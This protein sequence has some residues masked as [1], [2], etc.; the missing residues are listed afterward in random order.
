MSVDI[1][2]CARLKPGNQRVVEIEPIA[3]GRHATGRGDRVDVI[4]RGHGVEVQAT[5]T[6][7]ENKITLLGTQRDGDERQTNKENLFNDHIDK[8]FLPQSRSKGM[9]AD[10]KPLTHY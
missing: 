1:Q 3:R 9:R 7:G 2:W 4:G 6:I 10:R 5:V 8:I